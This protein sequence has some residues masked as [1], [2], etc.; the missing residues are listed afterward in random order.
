MLYEICQFQVTIKIRLIAPMEGDQHQYLYE[1]LST[2]W[3]KRLSY[4][5]SVSKYLKM[6]LKYN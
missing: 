2:E 4:L 1:D 6:I 3:M 5:I